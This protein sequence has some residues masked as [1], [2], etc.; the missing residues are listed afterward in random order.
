MKDSHKAFEFVFILSEIIL[1][2]IFYL[3]TEYGVGVHPS[4]SN[5]K[6]ELVIARD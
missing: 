4:D 6:E 2:V 1:V 5:S 3:C